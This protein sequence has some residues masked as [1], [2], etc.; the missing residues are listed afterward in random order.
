MGGMDYGYPAGDTLVEQTTDADWDWLEPRI[1]AELLKTPRSHYSDWDRRALV[2]LLVARAKHQG[3]DEQAETAIL[4]FG[5]PQQ[6]AFFHLEQ[7]NFEQAVAIA[8]SHFQDLPGLVNQFA[9]A[10]LTAGEP[11]RAAALVTELA[12]TNSKGYSYEDWFAKFYRDYG[13]PEQFVAAQSELLKTRFTLKGYQDLQAQAEPLGQWEAIRQS[14]LTNLEAKNGYSQLIE[15][16]LWEKD[17]EMA[18]YNLRQIR[19]GNRTAHQERVAKAIQADQP[20]TAIALYQELIAAAINQRGRDN[21]RQA[22]QYLQ[23]IRPLC[24]QLGRAEEFQGYVEQVR[25]QNTRLPALQQE[26]D[27]AGL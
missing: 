11:D 7:G 19:A 8:R 18:L 24:T 9:D 4:S 14:L 21:Y 2:D 1:Q 26:L 3:K 23:A 15:I 16:A 10:L 5:A 20:G 27:K 22:A 6:K 17:W 25:S 13:Q 12:Q